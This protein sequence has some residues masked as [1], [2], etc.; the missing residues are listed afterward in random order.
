MPDLKTL[1]PH[2]KSEVLRDKKLVFSGLV[3]NNMKLEQSKAFLI[4]KSLGA[5]VT[6][7]L[8]DTTTHLVAVTI[9]KYIFGYM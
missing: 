5:I 2:V 8:E 9:G 7:S 6:Q 1:I 3:P 4:A